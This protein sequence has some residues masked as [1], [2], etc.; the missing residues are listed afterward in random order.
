MFRLRAALSLSQGGEKQMLA[1]LATAS[2]GMG[3]AGRADNPPD[4]QV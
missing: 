1:G 4:A 2:A 3:D